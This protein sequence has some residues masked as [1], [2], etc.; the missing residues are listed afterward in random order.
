MLSKINRLNQD[1]EIKEVVKKGQTFFLPQFVFKYYKN[2]ENVV[3]IGFI[4][5]TKV[6]KRAVVRNR[7]ARQMREATRILLP[8]LQVG[9][10]ILII[11][12]QQALSLEFADIVKQFTF[13]FSKIKI[14]NKV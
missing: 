11:A 10:S 8:D 4:V 12:K 1:K 6:D 9:Y 5:S 3:K 14:Y 7:L 13:A 2:K